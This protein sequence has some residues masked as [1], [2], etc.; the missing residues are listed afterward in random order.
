MISLESRELRALQDALMYLSKE[1]AENIEKVRKLK[2]DKVYFKL[3]DYA[4]R[5]ST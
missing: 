2:L 5:Q 3:D 1:Q 4:V